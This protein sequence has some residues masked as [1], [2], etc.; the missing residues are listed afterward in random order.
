V[1]ACGNS[2]N[3]H[4]TCSI[5]VS[6][7]PKNIGAE[8]GLLTIADEY[9]SQA[10]SLA[11]VGIAPPGVSLTPTFVLGFAPLGVGIISAGQTVTLTNNSGL[12]LSVAGFTVTGDFL[13]L[14]GSNTCSK[15]LAANSACT[16][17]IAF[18]PTGAAAR[19]GSLTVTDNAA[20]SSQTLPLTGTGVDFTLVP[21]NSSAAIASGQS[22]VYPLLLTSI[23]GVPGA[24]V[25]T[26]TGVPVN[27]TCLVVP[28]TVG[29]GTGTVLVT[30]TVQT[31]V[32][33]AGLAP[34]RR[35]LWAALLLPL[36][37][38]F[39]VLRRRRSNFRALACFVILCG[40]LAT[41]SCGSGRLIP[42]STV[43]SPTTPPVSPNG[44]STIV[45]SAASAGLVRTVNLTL[46][47]Q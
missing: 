40:L 9:R 39:P 16:L 36:W 17:Q 25:F 47:I 15:M 20:S 43:S 22:A 8:A 7:V 10:I 29:L 32:V 1:N 18:A 19:S 12:P 30:V 11:G 5:G 3:A 44:S 46:T 42:D 26:C 45:V 27:A 2:L 6:Y 28:G 37:M 13:I 33:T 35:I 14:P 41:A 24:A 38:G 21:G 23:S 34:G 31:G 4:S